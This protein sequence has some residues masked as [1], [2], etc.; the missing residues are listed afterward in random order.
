V[1]RK[2]GMSRDD[3]LSINLKV[4]EQVGA[5]IKK[6][7]PNAF[8]ICITNPLDAMVWALQKA[9]GLPKPM[10]IGMAGVLDSALPHDEFAR[11]AQLDLV[12]SDGVS[13]IDVLGGNGDGTFAPASASNIGSSVAQRVGA[14]FNGVC[15]PDVAVLDASGVTVLRNERLP[16]VIDS[17][18]DLSR[19]PQSVSFT[20]DQQVSMAGPAAV[21]VQKVGAGPTTPFTPDGESYDS[22]SRTATFTFSHPLPDGNYVAT[23]RAATVSSVSTLNHPLHDYTTSFFT[24]A[25]DVNHD[26]KVDFADLLILARNYGKKPAIYQQ[27]D[28]DYDGA[29]GFD[30]LVIL[31]RAYGHSLAAPAITGALIS[32][33]DAG[34]ASSLGSQMPLHLAMVRRRR[35]GARSQQ[36]AI[37]CAATSTFFGRGAYRSLTTVLTALAMGRSRRPQ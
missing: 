23:L 6:Y 2:P 22:Y 16:R 5:G 17:R 33:A 36:D 4:M 21:S 34:T 20:F 11:V 25:G 27:G 8:V 15:E 18:F 3:L 26:R 29:V 1:P 37:G 19:Q 13:S 12:V 24:L 30:D 10:V 32:G 35:T 28:L 7:A 9:C 31:A 14:D